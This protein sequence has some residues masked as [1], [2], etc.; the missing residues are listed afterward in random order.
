MK[1][2]I[3]IKDLYRAYKENLIASKSGKP[4]SLKVFVKSLTD[5]SSTLGKT[6]LSNKNGKLERIAK[7][8]KKKNRGATIAMIASATKMAKRKKSAKSSSKE[9]E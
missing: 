1:P 5:D 2:S 4:V 8:E 6:W 7:A 9:T 3:E